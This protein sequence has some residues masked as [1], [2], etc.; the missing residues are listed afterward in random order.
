LKNGDVREAL[1]LNFALDLK[2]LESEFAQFLKD[3]KLL[4]ADFRIEAQ[5]RADQPIAVL[6]EAQRLA[7]LGDFL[8]IANRPAEATEMLERSLKVDPDQSLALSSL[9]LVKARK[10]YYE[11]AEA[12]AERAIQSDPD[13]FLFHYRYAAALSRREMTKFGFVSGYP[14]PLAEKMRIALARAIEL[15]P[16]FAEAYALL[17]FVNYVRNENLNESRELIG[18]ALR[19][20]PGNQRYLLRLAEIELRQEKFTEARKITLEVHRTAPTEQLKLYSQ[21]TLQRID[22]TENQLAKL[23]DEKARYVNDEIVTDKPLSEEE[24]RRR[25]EKATVEQTRIMLKRPK[26]EET[27]ILASLIRVECGKERIEFIFKSASGPLKLQAKSFDGISLWSFIEDMSE[28]SLG[29]G[30]LTRD[31]NASVIYKR[32][33]ETGTAAELLSIEFVP[34]SFQLPN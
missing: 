8:S 19:I 9:A 21:N 29:C 30:N 6:G 3:P 4:I 15:N 2:S 27:R 23:R 28:Y 7:V 1:F 5:V 33:K 16:A 25:R 32:E 24:I 12:L 31:N 17:C 18:Q 13:N 22:S 14:R 11:D 20:A 26:F 34:K 10:F